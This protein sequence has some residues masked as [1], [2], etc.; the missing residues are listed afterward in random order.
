MKRSA[1]VELVS[2]LDAA[3]KFHDNERKQKSDG[4]TTILDWIDSQQS[5]A[6]RVKKN[7][8]YNYIEEDCSD[9]DS[10]SENEF[11]WDPSQDLVD[12]HSSDQSFRIENDDEVDNIDRCLGRR[13]R[14]SSSCDSEPP[15]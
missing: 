6:H 3:Y 9:S 7:R 5:I 4:Q 10:T 8:R 13:E 15:A 14:E 11:D 1:M 2:Q 12:E